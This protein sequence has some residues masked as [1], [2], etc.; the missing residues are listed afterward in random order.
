MR[1]VGSLDKW[2]D[3]RHPQPCI[4]IISLGLGYITEY[5]KE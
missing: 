4:I 3:M 5:V 2:V 1:L